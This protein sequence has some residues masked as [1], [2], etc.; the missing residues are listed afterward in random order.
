MKI[1]GLNSIV[2]VKGATATV[3]DIT[4]KDVVL[5]G[6]DNTIHKVP[7]KKINKMIDENDL[8]VEHAG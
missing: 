3:I 4:S 2:K 5:T 8:K 1:L 6:R 7:L